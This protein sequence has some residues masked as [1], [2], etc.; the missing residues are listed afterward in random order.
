[1]KL[2]DKPKLLERR[3]LQSRIEANADTSTPHAASGGRQPSPT[4]G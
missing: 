4:S 2:A 1:M 3:L